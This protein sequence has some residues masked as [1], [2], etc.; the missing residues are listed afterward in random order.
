MTDSMPG[1]SRNPAYPAGDNMCDFA[2]LFVGEP[3][4]DGQFIGINGES[5]R[6][7]R[8]FLGNDGEKILYSEIDRK[9]KAME[10]DIW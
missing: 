8:A 1:E 7:I 6:D 10:R 2:L 4:Q 9:L 3:G 5:T